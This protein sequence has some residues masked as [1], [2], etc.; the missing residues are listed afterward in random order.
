[1]EVILQSLSSN[2]YLTF[3]IVLLILWIKYE[4]SLKRLCTFLYYGIFRKSKTEQEKE[5]NAFDIRTELFMN[6][7]SAKIVRVES[8]NLSKDIGRNTFY[9]Y[10]VKTMLVILRDQFEKDLVDYKKGSLSREKFCSYHLYHKNNIERFKGVYIQCIRQ[11]LTEE[12][13]EA[14]D[15]N[16][17]VSIFF[18]WSF[19]QFEILAELISSC[20]LPEEIIMSWWIFFYEFYSTLERFGLLINGRITG[21]IFEGIKLG[22]PDPKNQEEKING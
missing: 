3:L 5:K 7:I 21:R 22:L 2:V 14:D 8:L 19:P 1:M 16:Y 6:R 17:V 18:Q 15:I 12:G 11:K 13:W 9:H 20:K 4:D 10:L